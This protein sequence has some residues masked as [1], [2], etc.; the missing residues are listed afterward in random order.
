M[1]FTEQSLVEDY[2]VEKLQSSGWTLIPAEELGRDDYKE[3]LLIPILTRALKRINEEIDIGDEEIRHVLNELRFEGTGSE[4][5]KQI[6]NIY[7]FGIP[8]K[9]EKEKVVRYVQLFDYETT[10]KNGFI[11]SKQVNYDGRE[12]IRT[13]I[14]LY[15]NGIPLVNIEC[16]NPASL[17]ESWFTAYKDIKYYENAV[18]ELYKYVQIGVAAESRAKYFPIVPWQEE[19]RTYEW[20]EDL[21]DSID[22]MIEMLSGDTL[23]EIVKD[24]LFFRIEFGNATKVITRYMQYRAAKKMVNRVIDNLEGREE[25]NKGLIW[26][27]QGSGKTLTMIFAANKLYYMSQLGN[28]SIFFIVD[29]IDLEDQLYEEFYALDI[30]EP[31]IIDSIGILKEVLSFDGYRGKRGIFITLIHKF[32]PEE[33]ANLQKEIRIVSEERETIS[34][35][36]NVVA[37]IDEGHRTQYGI[38]AAQMKTILRSAFFFALTGTPISKRWKDTYMEFSYPPV[39]NYLDRYF[40]TDSIRD[41]FTVK[42]AYQPRLEDLHLKKKMLETF[43]EV[44]FEELPYTIREK[45]EEQVKSRLNPIV[46]FLESP[47]RIKTVAKD[48]A[49]HFQENVDGRFKAMVVAASRNS[50]I[51]YKEE[52][53]RHLPEEY[54]EVV[55][56]YNGKKD[57]AM[58]RKYLERLK[59]RFAGKDPDAIK[60]RIVKKFK[61]EEFPKI[62]IVTDM[63]LAGFDAPLLQTMYLDKPLKEDRLLQAVARTNRPLGDLKEAGVVIDYVGVLKELKRTLEIYSEEDIKGAFYS[64]ESIRNEFDT[65]IKKIMGM[66]K[67]IPIGYDREMLLN[68]IESITTDYNVE[69]EFV[70]DYRKLRKIFE[71]LGSDEIKLGRFEEYRWISAIYTYYMKVLMQRPYEDYVQKYLKKTV[72]FVHKTTE[73][74]KLEKELPVIVFDEDYLRNLEE[75]VKSTKEKAAN[76]L[77][78]L[79]R[80]VLVDRRKNPVYESLTDMV[81]RLMELWRKKTKDYE[82][83]YT[84]GVEIIGEMARRSER[85]RE[86]GFSDM[87]YSLLLTLDEK[88]GEGEN[89]IGDVRRLSAALSTYMFTGWRLQTTA[90]KQVERAVRRFARGY[91]KRCGIGH[92]ELNELYGRLIEDVKNYGS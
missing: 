65:L 29:R 73:I 14:M 21:K 20:R 66:F 41:G 6:L 54:S 71:L 90:R 70:E 75:N 59:R 57:P 61:E 16:K 24:F 15:V 42:I 60:K 49:E 63:L 91:V 28:P 82:T 30:V 1:P 64:I 62:L 83:I 31:E 17:S 13:D 32:R 9:F 7:K 2:I 79:N 51:L 3:P 84:E 33:L 81:E 92:D 67:D 80:L 56:S 18:P 43:L 86:I 37:F 36:R 10:S 53:D 40:V 78:T 12:R 85:Q 19:V 5:A 68:A 26:H 35:R 34:D 69:N 46:L 45:V 88:F 74:T 48:I 23:L 4:G 50:C 77:F 89:L 47:E 25:K 72:R 55:M 27:W 58:I 52:L 22:S 44:E 11:A 76:I 8:V 87:E 38:L 39:E